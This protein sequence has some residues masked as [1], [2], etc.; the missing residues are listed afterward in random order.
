M[1]SWCRRRR[2][3]ARGYADRLRAH[4]RAPSGV[5]VGNTMLGNIKTSMAGTYRAIRKKHMVRY[6]AEF[7]WREFDF[8]RRCRPRVLT[9][10]ATTR[11]VLRATALT[12][13]RWRDA[14]LC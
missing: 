13:S 9:V 8:P 3:H 10:R 12:R 14:A 11:P 6:L 2:L 4:G 5:Q 7:E 1:L